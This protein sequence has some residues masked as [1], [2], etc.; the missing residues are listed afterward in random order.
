MARL[1]VSSSTR[2]PD[3]FATLRLLDPNGEEVIL[4]DP[5]AHPGYARLATGVAPQARPGT[6]TALPALSQS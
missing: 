6:H 4:V 3:L 2:D 1:Y 5:Q